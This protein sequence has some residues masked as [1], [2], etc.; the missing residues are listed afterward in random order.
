MLAFKKLAGS[1][2]RFKMFMGMSPQEFEFL[3][4]KVK[5]MFPEEERKRLPKRPRQRWIGCYCS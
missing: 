4:A 1:A 3:L 5:G 2:R